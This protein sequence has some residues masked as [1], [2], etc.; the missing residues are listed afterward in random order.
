MWRG[1]GSRLNSA[2]AETNP[3]GQPRRVVSYGLPI[4]VAA[5]LLSFASWSEPAPIAKRAPRPNADERR[6]VSERVS[7]SAGLRTFLTH[8]PTHSLTHLVYLLSASNQNIASA[9]AIC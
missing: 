1:S 3:A 6:L 9:R 8:P 7:E 4:V 2:S 5:M